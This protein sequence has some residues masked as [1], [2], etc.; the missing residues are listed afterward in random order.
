MICYFEREVTAL[1]SGMNARTIW[2]LPALPGTPV[3]AEDDDEHE[4]ENPREK[5]K[6]LNSQC[7]SFPRL[8]W[9]REVL[10]RRRA[11]FLKIFAIDRD[12]GL[13][14]PTTSGHQPIDF[15]R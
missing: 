12:R 6:I 13:Q 15:S 10:L 7:M 8:R 11:E 2:L 4:D 1:L 14:H 5:N 3:F 9:E